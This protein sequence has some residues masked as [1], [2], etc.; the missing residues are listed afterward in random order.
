MGF[1]K[2]FCASLFGGK[3]VTNKT[4]DDTNSKDR[5]I[6]DLNLYIKKL[7]EEN[8]KKDKLI[9]NKDALLHKKNVI[10]QQKV[11]ELSNVQQKLDETERLKNM[12]KNVLL[13]KT[14]EDSQASERETY[15]HKQEY[16]NKYY[17]DQAPTTNYPT[18]KED[19][20]V[21]TI[22]TIGDIME[23]IQH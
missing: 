4:N 22:D 2:N 12:F 17:S 7:K 19:V 20:T 15:K 11:E 13:K 3:K 5:K 23:E 6:E 10:I 18:E 16:I 9:Q 8:A 1:F 14:I 21:S